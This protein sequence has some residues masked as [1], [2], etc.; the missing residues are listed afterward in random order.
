MSCP[1]FLLNGQTSKLSQIKT[2][3][4]Q[5]S[6]LGSLLFLVYISDLT[7]GITSNVKLFAEDTLTFSVVRDSSFSWLSLNEGLS[8]ISQL[9]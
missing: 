1:K 9:G 8:K 6:I 4:P 3:V 5:G 7:E 2:G